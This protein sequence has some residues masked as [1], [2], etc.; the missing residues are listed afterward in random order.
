MAKVKVA[1]ASSVKVSFGKRR[2]GKAK[3]R[4]NKH[5]KNVSKYKGQGR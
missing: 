5:A 4:A 3:K 1:K 2:I